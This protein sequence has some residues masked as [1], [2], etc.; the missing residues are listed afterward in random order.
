M[1][2]TKSE[3]VIWEELDGGALLIDTKSGSRW[4]LSAAAA[5]TWKL[6]D[7]KRTLGEMAEVLCQKRAIIAEFC[8][9]FEVLGL[10]KGQDVVCAAPIVFSSANSSPFSF[11]SA[12]IG[13]SPRRRP[14][15]RGNSGPG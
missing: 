10:L 14:S 8:A 6:C 15:P 11:Q 2:W 12:G 13:S 1:R 4:T 5:A 9:Q 3:N 7:G